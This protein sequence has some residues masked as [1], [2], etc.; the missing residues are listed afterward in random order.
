[1][2]CVRWFSPEVET[3]APQWRGETRTTL[4]WT[5]AGQPGEAGGE[6]QGFFVRSNGLDAYAKGSGGVFRAAHEKIAADLAH[7]LGLPIPPVTL[8]DHPNGEP[9]SVSLIPFPA[10]QKWGVASQAP[11][12]MARMAPQL[13]KCRSAMTVFDTW[14]DNRDRVN[15]GNVI[16]T[17]ALN[18]G[19]GC[20]YIDYAYSLSHGWGEGTAPAITTVVP[21]YPQ[22]SPPAPVD[23]AVL[24]ATLEAIEA[25]PDAKI[26]E[27]VNRVPDH[28]LTPS[29]QA[30]IVGGLV[31][32]KAQLRAA[33][34]VSQGG[35]L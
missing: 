29:R 34:A 16:V 18:G 28:F 1:M 32:R 6:A 26:E 33:F 2:E 4:R 21:H 12:S 31:G 35:V 5:Q 9:C 30:T 7:D 19:F 17:L 15:D 25:F 10:P 23:L 11:Q 13:A 27:V 22:P 24:R 3:V 8:W 20:A 14:V